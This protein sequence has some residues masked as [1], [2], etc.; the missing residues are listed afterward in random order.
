MS[1][2]VS[3]DPAFQDSKVW[4][5]QDLTNYNE[6][7]CKRV[8]RMDPKADLVVVFGERTISDMAMRRLAVLTIVRLIHFTVLVMI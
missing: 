8:D 4:L 5:P 2:T 1:I 7:F 3:P 6:D